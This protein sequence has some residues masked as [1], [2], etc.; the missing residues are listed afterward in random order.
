[1][2]QHPF[3][4]LQYHREQILGLPYSVGPLFEPFILKVTEGLLFH[5]RFLHKTVTDLRQVTSDKVTISL[6]T[7]HP[8]RDVKSCTRIGK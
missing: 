8:I 2:E 6:E 4:G 7:F 5:S 3:N 1:M